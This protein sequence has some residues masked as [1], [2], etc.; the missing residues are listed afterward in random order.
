MKDTF[1]WDVATCS[2][3]E[4]NAYIISYERNFRFQR[5]RLG[6]RTI[7]MVTVYSFHQQ[8]FQ[9]YTRVHGVTHRK[10]AKL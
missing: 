5:R 6:P 2:L 8:I 3:V 4:I 9:V 10:T 7:K 1:F